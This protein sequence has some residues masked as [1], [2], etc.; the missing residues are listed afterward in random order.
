MN[1]VK[2]FKRLGLSL[3]VV[4]VLLVSVLGLQLKVVPLFTHEG[5]IPKANIQVQYTIGNPA[6]AASTPDYI[7]DGVDD[8]VQFQAA[9]NALPNVGGKLVVL[10]GQYNFSATVSRAINNIVIQGVG[11]GT[12]IT[13]NGVNPP[14]SVGGQTGW[15][16][17]DL[18]T[19][20]GGITVAVDTVFTNV[21]I[22][23]TNYGY[24]V[25][26]DFYTDRWLNSSGNTFIGVNVVGAGNLTHVAGS[27]GYGNSAFGYQSLYSNTIGNTN[28]A[29]GYQA[30][31]SNTTGVSSSA[32][33]TS[34]A[35]AN[36]TGV[37]LCA[38]GT[39][40]L[41][42]SISG[43]DLDAFGDDTLYHN[44]TGYW[45]V[46]IGDSSLWTNTTGYYNFALGIQALYLNDTGHDNG[47]FGL[48]A[49]YSSTGN[50]NYAFG[51]NAAKYNTGNNNCAFGYSTLTGVDGSSTGSGN[52]GFGYQ[53]LSSST[54]GYNN[55]AFGIQALNANADGYNNAAFGAL[56]ANKTTS[57]NNI[58]ALGF[59]ALFNN[60]TGVSN[61]AIGALSGFTATDKYNNVFIGYHAGYY[62]NESNAFYVDTYDRTNAAGDQ[63]G[64][65]LYGKF[66]A[67]P[68]NQT[69]SINAG[70]ITLAYLP[71]YANNAAALAGGLTAGMLYRTN[72]DPDT[73]CVVH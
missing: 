9:L 31:Y 54:T 13:Y 55:A 70:K 36:T 39:N 67:T 26:R 49:L 20:A 37:G 24:R 19:D 2:L 60:T 25:G 63:V 33:G 42:N 62:A 11:I 73:V 27:D 56:A 40:A 29:F 30:L 5:G 72:G 23:T 17:Q 61:T 68:A 44:T 69:L 22:N 59:E 7:C 15:E 3:L 58:T 57:G 4:T 6:Y 21:V 28:S 45:S 8:N 14:F 53:V 47:A 1:K 50:Y 34:A 48:D 38:F 64:A 66:N 46:A 52:S 71:N 16:F 10:A 41:L 18:K 51:N 32:F 65:L 43:D 12:Y 35:K